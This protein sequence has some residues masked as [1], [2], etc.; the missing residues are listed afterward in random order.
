MKSLFDLTGRDLWLVGGAGHL[1]TA[2]TRA[3][4]AHG[5]RVLCADLGERAHAMV[6]REGLAASVTPATLDATDADA[7]AAWVRAKIAERG[8]PAGLV[9]MTY[10]SFPKKVTEVTTADFDTANRVNLTS[11]F[12]LAREAG[13][14]M[15]AQGRGSIVLFSSMYGTVSPDPGMY[16][17]PVNPN[18]IEYGVG[19]A[20]LQQMARYLAV[21]WAPRGV[22]CNAIAPGPFPFESQ[23]E[24]HP[25]WMT[26][27]RA[28]VP[29]GRVGRPEEM[30]GVVVFLTADASSY[31]TGHTLAVDG[32]WTA[33]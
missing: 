28:H 8:V 10:K 12:A 33:W 6:A 13:E 18:P 3:L 30:A 32:G 22:R 5:A 31:V 2:V 26:R 25:E 27:L 11:T 7:A 21:H 23:Q 9:T 1:G 15:A 24:T 14:A 20:G 19:K 4:A 29:M 17:P 16:P